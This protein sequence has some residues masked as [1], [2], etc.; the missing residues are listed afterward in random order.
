MTQRIPHETLTAIRQRTESATPGPW[1]YKV[2]FEAPDQPT[3]RNYDDDTVISVVCGMGTYE[4]AEFLTHAR[5]DIPMLLAEVDRLRNIEKEAEL[6]S[7][8]ANFL[9]S[10]IACGEEWTES[11]EY[12]RWAQRYEESISGGATE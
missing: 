9:K 4:D 2:P 8:Y 3:I 12:W 6:L 10:V 1:K 7:K 5:E 11:C